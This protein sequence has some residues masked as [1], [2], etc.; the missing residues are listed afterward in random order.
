MATV[1]LADADILKEWV[2]EVDER[3]MSVH[4]ARMVHLFQVCET[5]ANRLG[6]PNGMVY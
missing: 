2:I 1:K 6:N 5:I 4:D 3:W